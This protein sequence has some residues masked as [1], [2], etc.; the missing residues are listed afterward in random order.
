[1]L[2]SF[3]TV[4]ADTVKPRKGKIVIPATAN[5]WKHELITAQI[6]AQNGYDVTFLPIEAGFSGKS[7]DVL[8]MG[9][10][11]EIKSPKTSKLS[12]LERNLKKATKQSGN[13]I[14]DS[15]RLDGLHDTTIQK[16]LVQKFKQQKT[17][18]RLL[19]IN[20]KREAIDISTLLK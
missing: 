7:P 14:I 18:K 6:L 15:R 20:K 12:A 3:E 17:I 16:F 2:N 9:L 19:F 8:M 4:Y 5:V 11:W 13:I 10:K 1:M